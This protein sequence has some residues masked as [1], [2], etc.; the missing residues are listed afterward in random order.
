[1]NI[2]VKHVGAKLTAGLGALDTVRLAA[3][4]EARKFQIGLRACLQQEARRIDFKYG[5]EHP[6]ARRLAARLDAN[7]EAV[8]AL[9][10]EGEIARIV[11]PEVGAQEALVHGRVVDPR[12]RGIAGLVACLTDSRGQPL[13]NLPS[14]TADASGY[15]A[16]ALDEAA[17]EILA[18]Y[19]AGAFL[20]VFG[21]DG[22]PV[23]RSKQSLA[24]EPGAR[25]VVEVA[26]NRQRPGS[27][28]KP[29][30][31][32][33]ASEYEDSDAEPAKPKAKRGASARK[34]TARGKGKK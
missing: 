16:L 9:E 32:R 12:S 30:Q 27:G 3:L 20:A 10:V 18:S 13:P 17:F 25:L 21:G 31:R 29:K 4:D 11:V 6:R 15:Y 7:L 8:Q 26:L 5:P 33:R 1:M 28:G 34:K 22:K 24:I 14:A 23:Y 19:R 2:D